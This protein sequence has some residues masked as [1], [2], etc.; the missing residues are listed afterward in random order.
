MTLGK[1]W[2]G[3]WKDYERIREIYDIDYM[4]S[5]CRYPPYRHYG[6]EEKTGV[7]NFCHLGPSPNLHRW[8]RERMS[9]KND[10]CW[11]E[12]AEKYRTEIGNRDYDGKMDM[13]YRQIIDW[14]QK[15]KSVCMLCT[16]KMDSP[17]HR[18]LL[19]NNMIRINR[20][21][22]RGGAVK[23]DW[24]FAVNKI[25]DLTWENYA[26]HLFEEKGRIGEENK[27]ALGCPHV[28]MSAAYDRLIRKGIFGSDKPFIFLKG[29]ALESM[30][31]K[32]NY[33]KY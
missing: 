27:V 26:V 9:K 19:W 13:Q 2:Y 21:P 33:E 12:Y 3:S 30:M 29:T 24:P 4:V 5:I 10:D 16:C 17:C 22:Y 7:L 8:R 23:L 15:G 28:E 6:S 32:R 1:I 25:T 14:V 11:T 18:F 31:E 20:I